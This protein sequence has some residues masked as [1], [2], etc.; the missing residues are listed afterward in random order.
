MQ[1]VSLII[2]SLLVVC[3][4]YSGTAT[5]SGRDRNQSLKTSLLRLQMLIQIIGAVSKA[6]KSSMVFLVIWI[7]LSQEPQMILSWRTLVD[8][9]RLYD[10]DFQSHHLDTN[11]KL[12][13][14]ETSA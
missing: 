11:S 4:F 9:K 1:C 12:H 5:L 13:F 3:Q 10:R 6:F 2:S 14:F 8:G 7:F